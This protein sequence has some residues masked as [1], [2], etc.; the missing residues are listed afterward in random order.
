MS[1]AGIITTPVVPPRTEQHSCIQQHKTGR[2]LDKLQ[3]WQKSWAPPEFF[4]GGQK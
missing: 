3:H 4:A 2:E 1:N